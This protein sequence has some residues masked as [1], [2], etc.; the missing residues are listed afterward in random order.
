MS[1]GK[2][3]D[4]LFEPRSIAVVGASAHPERPSHLIME[5][6]R[7]IGFPGPVYPVNPRYGSID[8]LRCYGSIDE[9]EDEIDLAIL[10]IPAHEVLEVLRRPLKNLRGAI[11]V[12]AG[13]KEVEGTGAR[14]ESELREIAEKKDIR[15]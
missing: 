13:F 1:T 5:S 7:K 11:V 9:I 6:L 15:M 12:S 2:D 14:L 8:G 3:I 10:A 4:F